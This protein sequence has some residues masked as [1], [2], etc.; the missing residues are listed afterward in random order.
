[1]SRRASSLALVALVG[2]CAT[3]GAEGEGDRDL[4]SAG[5]GPFRKLADAEVLG[6]APFVL[7]DR[8]A[9]YREPSA[10]AGAE[11]VV[12]VAVASAPGGRDVIV[13][14]RAED[15]RSFFGTTGDGGRRP[16]IVLAPELAW[17]GTALSG[18]AALRRGEEWLLY[19]AGAGGI[20]VARSR[21]GVSFTREPSPV[22]A[23]D[24]RAGAW[25]T[26]A[27]RAPGV[28]VLPD[29]RVRLLYA[30]GGALG[31]AES[32]DGVRFRRLDADPATLELDPV[33]AASRAVVP[34]SGAT[35]AR[36]AFDAR[37]VSDPVALRRVTPAGRVHL[38]VL[39][40][41]EDPEG[42]SA[43]GFA[44]RYGDE[45]RLERAAAPVYAVGQHERAPSVVEVGGTTLLYVGQER[46]VDATRTATGIACAVAPANV[47][48]PPPASFP[49]RP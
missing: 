37:A 27:P 38:R 24:P 22:L 8:D 7:E 41:G 5:V 2:A 16:P 21:D 49:P 18:P 14:T 31:A 35:P 9:R 30:A 17:E 40:T 46:R 25:E 45:G 20:G 11:G 48:L 32:E 12:L 10:V 36:W 19:Y 26:S 13:R 43:V 33:L 4:P 23:A 1:M 42:G 47:Q 29:G 34:A 3:S 28:Y 15:G 6:I 39:Y 44:A